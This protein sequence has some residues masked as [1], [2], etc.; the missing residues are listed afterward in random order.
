MVNRAQQIISAR[1]GHPSRPSLFKT[2]TGSAAL[3]VVLLLTLGTVVAVGTHA[4]VGRGFT[5]ADWAAIRF[6]VTQALLSATISVAIAIPTARALA[7]RRFRGRQVMVALLGAPFILPAIVAVLGIVSIWGRSGLISD[8]L[9][10]FGLSPLNIYGFSGVVLAHVFFNLPLATRMILQGWM[11]VPAEHFR[12]AAELGF[13]SKDVNRQLERPMLRAAVPGAFLLVFLLCL[14]SFAVALSLGGGPRATTI[15]LAIYQALRFDFDLSKAAL[16]SML[17]FA[18]CTATAG[19]TLALAKPT[20]FSIGLDHPPARWDGTELS[21]RLMDTTLLLTVALFL[22]APLVSVILRGLPPLF[23]L[24]PQIWPSLLNSLLIAIPAALLAT[25]LALALAALIT[26]LARRTRAAALLEAIGFL[27]LAA[28]PFVIGTGLFILLNPVVDPFRL[29]L[30][31]TIAVNATMSLPF[32]LRILLPALQR[33]EDHY[34]RLGA[35]LDMTG[36]TLFRIAIW[37]RIKRAAG[38]A[39]GLSAALSMGDL[40]VIALFAPP[41]FATLPLTM[42]RLMA[43]YQ[44]EAAAGAALLL[45]GT[46]LALFWLFDRGGR[47]DHNIR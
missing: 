14:T 15:E 20:A 34:G 41:D 35:S 19:A 33:A 5:P 31:I 18:L 23:A 7:R 44:M 28:S 46:S 32:A 10:A 2:L 6:T 38:F 39:A 29:A 16:L 22:F 42:Y 17:Q 37:P 11:A 47:L 8:G 27:A 30:P 25:A 4:T 26:E 9:T 1:Q 40:G 43:A 24:P 3:L 21:T 12:L 36:L 13:T 45:V